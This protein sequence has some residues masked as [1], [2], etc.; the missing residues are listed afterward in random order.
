MDVCVT[1]EAGTAAEH[2]EGHESQSKQGIEL[3]VIAQEM[4]DGLDTR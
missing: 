2:L 3:I 4:R 1:V